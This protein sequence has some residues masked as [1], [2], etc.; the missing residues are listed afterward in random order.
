MSLGLLVVAVAA[1]LGPKAVAAPVQ[2]IAAVDNDPPRSVHI[3]NLDRLVD[4]VSEDAVL[5]HKAQQLATSRKTAVATAGVGAIVGLALLVSA[6]TFLEDQDSFN[7]PAFA[8]GLA[9]IVATPFAA[10]AISPSQA[11]QLDVL[12]AWNSRH[13]DRPLQLEADE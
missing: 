5:R 8:A 1:S 3:E 4:L 2:P 9:V 10:W 13:P 12:K 11:D 7:K 6:F